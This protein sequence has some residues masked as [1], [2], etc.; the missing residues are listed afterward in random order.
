MSASCPEPPTAGS[1]VGSLIPIKALPGQAR[2]KHHHA[3]MEIESDRSKES[4]LAGELA[5][6][7]CP[8][9]GADAGGRPL[10]G[11]ASL[12]REDPISPRRRRD[13][14]ALDACLTGSSGTDRGQAIRSGGAHGNP[15][16]QLL[17]CRPNDRVRTPRRLHRPREC[18]T[19]I[20]YRR[21][22]GLR[23]DTVART[24]LPNHNQTQ[25]RSFGSALASIR[26]GI[27]NPS[28]NR[29]W[30]AASRPWACPYRQ[31][32]SRLGPRLP[33][34]ISTWFTTSAILQ[35]HTVRAD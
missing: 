26:S 31:A 8:R 23:D 13:H 25:N 16:S 4:Q 15:G 30:I 27:A 10:G 2:Y 17:A 34:V 33:P 32:H 22:S 11:R 19:E 3:F 7:P 12:R 35:C 28:V 18:G 9:Q 5:S 6:W 20:R 1:I 21:Q 14:T 29:P 24:S